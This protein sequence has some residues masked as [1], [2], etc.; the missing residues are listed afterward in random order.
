[1]G[2]ITNF[3]TRIAKAGLYAKTAGV[4]ATVCVVGGAGYGGYKVVQ[5]RTRERNQVQT[6]TQ[7]QGTSTQI[8]N[9]TQTSEQQ[10]TNYNGIYVGTATAAQGLTGATV[11]VADGKLTGPATY[12]GTYYGVSNTV[13]VTVVG[14][15]S[16]TGVVKGT[17]TGTGSI[18]GQSIK[19]SGNVSGTI[20]GMKMNCSWTATVSGTSA[21][22]KMT[23]TKK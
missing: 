18:M 13:G 7:N 10:K 11:T 3:T 22:G 16:D 1:M 8:Q 20:T 14:T 12:K 19:V 17:F 2:L 23:L 5:N 4:V 21:S 6:Q 15:V 9:K